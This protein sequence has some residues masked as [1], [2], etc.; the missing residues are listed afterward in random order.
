M[1]RMGGQPRFVAQEGADAA[2]GYL[3]SRQR[4][5]LTRI[6]QLDARDDELQSQ[7]RRTLEPLMLQADLYETVLAWDKA[8]AVYEII[9]TKGPEWSRAHRLLGDLLARLARYEEAEPHLQTAL[10]RSGDKKET[11][12][13]A[14]SLALASEVA[15]PRPLAP[16]IPEMDEMLGATTSVDAVIATLTAQAKLANAS[17]ICGLPLDKPLV[18]HLD[19]L[20]GLA[21]DSHE[22][23]D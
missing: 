14:S 7:K 13:A 12:A 23:R 22:D 15:S 10:D 3:S 6:D 9:V 5:I 20:L 18:P 21:R 16:I 19:G 11:A 8:L 2:L 17:A 4:E 1:E